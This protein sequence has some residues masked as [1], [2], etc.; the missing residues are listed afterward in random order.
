MIKQSKTKIITTTTIIK[1][2]RLREERCK[3]KHNTVMCYRKGN[4]SP[5][6]KTSPPPSKRSIIHWRIKLGYMNS[7]RPSKPNLPSTPKPSKLLAPTRLRRTFV[8][9]S[10]LD[11]AISPLHQ[12]ISIGPFLIASQALNNLLTDMDMVRKGFG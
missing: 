10:I 4:R 8:F 12:P 9:S 2:Q 5:R 1:W 11:S 7:R 6:H 3:H